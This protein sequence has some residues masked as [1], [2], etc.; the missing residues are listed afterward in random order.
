MPSQKEVLRSELG[1]ALVKVTLQGGHGTGV[2]CLHRQK[3]ADT[4]RPELRQS[5]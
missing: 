3:S 4:E 5:E 2:G 1:V